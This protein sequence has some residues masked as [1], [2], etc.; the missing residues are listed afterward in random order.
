M[1]CTCSM[2]FILAER[3]RTHWVRKSFRMLQTRAVEIRDV[4]PR[5]NHFG[6]TGVTSYWELKNRISWYFL[7]AESYV[8]MY[9]LQCAKISRPTEATSPTRWMLILTLISSILSNPLPTLL[10][11]ACS[12]DLI[13]LVK[14]HAIGIA[15][16]VRI[17]PSKEWWF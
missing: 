15:G 10:L 14:S 12:T 3:S 16:L 13:T 5:P 7:N 2:R 4:D 9:K 6:R 1:S 11:L 17:S 8:L